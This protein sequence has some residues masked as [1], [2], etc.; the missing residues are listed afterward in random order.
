M[1][2]VTR[3]Y[4]IQLPIFEGPL[5]LLLYLIEQEE[6]DI[7]TVA[8]AQV[9]DQY[10]AHLEA[11]EKR[12]VRDLTYFLVV[13]AK[14]LLIKSQALLPGPPS[15][16]PEIEEETEDD[17]VRQLQIYK[18]FKKIAALLKERE[19]QVL[20]SYVRIAAPPRPA[21][22]PD[23]GNTTLSDLLTIVQEAL[24]AIPAPSADEVVAPIV[25]SIDEQIV[26]IEKELAHRQ[27]IFFRD[28]LSKATS[29]LEI[30]V[31]LWAILELIKR[32]RVQVHQEHL[33]GEIVI[34]AS[35][36]STQDE[37]ARPSLEPTAIAP[38]P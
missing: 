37:I 31:T 2:A 4:T 10:I 16:V 11:L 8:L 19:A 18:R 38:T 15:D 9:T 7:T 28:I 1:K 33:F 32:D 35:P 12:Q 5:D 27:R 17:L 30:I 22:H 26:R 36:P 20:R 21:P 14:L 3:S 25:V 34:E 29:R 6:L 24:A 23:F 13:A